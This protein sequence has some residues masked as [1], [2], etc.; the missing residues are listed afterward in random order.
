MKKSVKK[1]LSKTKAP[2]KDRISG[3]K[4]NDK[5]SAKSSSSAKSIVFGERK[6]SEKENKCTY[7]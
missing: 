4:K 7:C 1:S 2:K 5:G 6:K 3:S